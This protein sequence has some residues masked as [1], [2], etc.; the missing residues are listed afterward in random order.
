MDAISLY[1]YSIREPLLT[2]L[3]LALN[4]RLFSLALLAISFLLLLAKKTD[5][6]SPLFV[7]LVLSIL[8][9]DPLK[10]F[11]AVPRPCTEIAAKVS[12]PADPALPSGHA[13]VAGAFLLASVG[14]PLFSFFL[15]LAMLISFSR[16]YLGIH[17]L[18]DISA[19]IAV[20]AVLYAL[21]E[22]AFTAYRKAVE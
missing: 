9:I 8:L 21:C 13:V 19:G 20:G 11:L 14:T 16:I 1:I 4:D 22:K 3:S 15:P 10:L 5:R 18:A 12:C 6:A 7:S 17:S 2:F